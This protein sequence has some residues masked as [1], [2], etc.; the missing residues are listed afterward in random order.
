[1]ANLATNGEIVP[2]GCLNRETGRF[3]RVNKPRA[4]TLSALLKVESRPRDPSLR[5]ELQLRFGKVPALIDKGAQFSCILQFVAEFVYSMGEPCVFR[6]CSV[7]CYLTDGRKCNVTDAV[8][9]HVRLL[10]F[11][12]SHEFKVFKGSRF[13]VIL[14]LD[15]LDRTVM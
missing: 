9:V 3:P 8:D 10:T 1:V 14:G 6:V 11:I 13:P 4:R 15:F 2:G 7:L 12:R 5:V